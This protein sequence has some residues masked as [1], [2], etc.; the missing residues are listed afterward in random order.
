MRRASEAPF[1]YG[2]PGMVCYIEQR[3]EQLIQCSSR[4][5]I[6]EAVQRALAGQSRIVAVWPGQ[7]RSDLFLI[8]DLDALALAVGIERA[9]ALPRGPV[10]FPDLAH[11]QQRF[12]INQLKA[13]VGRAES[14]GYGMHSTTAT[15][16]TEVEIAPYKRGSRLV[17]GGRWRWNAAKVGFEPVEV[18]PG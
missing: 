4:P 12:L 5:E 17:G 1:P 10:S 14:A 16:E 7:Y 6:R 18:W 9:E 8:D 13:S 11:H 2:Y 3:G 15:G